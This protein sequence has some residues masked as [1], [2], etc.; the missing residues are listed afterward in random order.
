MADEVEAPRINGT[1]NNAVFGYAELA[2]ATAQRIDAGVR[3]G[4]DERG[5]V[6]LGH[7]GDH[8]SDQLG[9]SRPSRKSD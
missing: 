1:N 6:L 2:H 3:V 5:S 7:L 4:E 8:R 9:L